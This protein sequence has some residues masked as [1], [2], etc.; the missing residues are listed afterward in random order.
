M[1]LGTVRAFLEPMPDPP[2]DRPMP[3]RRFALSLLVP[4]AMA[5]G[6]GI[7]FLLHECLVRGGH[8]LPKPGPR[9]YPPGYH[10]PSTSH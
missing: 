4:G 7:A 2:R 10:R 8:P 6:G 9:R 3:R 1:V 5:A